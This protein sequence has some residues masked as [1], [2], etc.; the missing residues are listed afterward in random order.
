M[1]NRGGLSMKSVFRIIAFIPD[2]SREVIMDAV[3]ATIK[4]IYPH[5]DFVFSWMAVRGSWR[6]LSGSH[7]FLG[8]QNEICTGQ[9]VRLEFCCYEDDIETAI[10]AIRKHHPYEEPVIDILRVQTWKDYLQ[11]HYH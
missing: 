10:H 7:P 8:T 11:D 5:Y 9:E 3:N 6:P 2:D 4:P 1:G